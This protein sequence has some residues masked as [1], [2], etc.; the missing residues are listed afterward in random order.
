MYHYIIIGAGSA[1]SVVAARLSEDASARILVLEAGPPDMADAAPPLP[2]GC[3]SG[4]R[5]RIEAYDRV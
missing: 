4:A 1:G 5:A 2:M 3:G